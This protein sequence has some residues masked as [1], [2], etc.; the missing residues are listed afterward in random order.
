[1]RNLTLVGRFRPTDI[2][3]APTEQANRM[4]SS[5]SRQLMIFI[6]IHGL[7]GHVVTF[8]ETPVN[9]AADVGMQELTFEQH[10]RPILKVACFHCH[11]EEENHEGGL[12]LRLV[13]L[14]HTGGES[15]PAVL[16][17]N[18]ENS[19]IWERISSDEMPEGSTKL[20]P[21][22]K[23]TIRQWIEQGTK[24]A[25]PEPDNVED[26]RFT[27]EELN[28]WAFQ[29]VHR[30]NIPHVEGYA[31][32]SAVDAFVAVRLKDA[33]LPFSPDADRRTYIRRVTF[34]LIGLPPTSDEVACFVSDD[35]PNAH[36]RLV[37]RLLASPQ[38]GVRWGRHWLDVA[39][40]AESDGG[41]GVDR[42]REH[43]WRYRDY[44]VNSFNGD[45]P[46]HRFFQEQLAGDELIPAGT[47]A[48]SK[49]RRELL[50]ATG[51]LRMAPDATQ[52]SNTLADRNMAVADTLHVVSTATFGLTIGCAQCHDHKYDPVTIDDYYR[53]RAIF[54]PAF[55][56]Q[57][58][59]QPEARL[60]DVTPEHVM[61]ERK[62]IE[63][64]VKVLQEEL[65]QRRDQV[66]QQIQDRKLADVPSEFRDATRVAVL[67]KAAER[68]ARQKELLDL[69]PMVKPISTIR[70]LLVEYDK[71]SYR[72]FEK[73]QAEIDGVRSQMPPLRKIMATTERPG[74]IP[75]SS[76][77]FRGNPKSPKR[78][79]LP[80]EV[81]VL[82][83]HGRNV[84]IPD[85][86]PA[87]STT[88]RRLAFAKRL[89]DGTHPLAARVFVNR[90]WM[91]H[92]GRG[93]VNTPSDFGLSGEQPSHPALLDWLADD[94]V[95]HDWNLKRLHRMI[96][97]STTYRQQSK[98]TAAHDSVD[99]E[100][101]LLG[102]MNL[103]RLEAEAIRDAILAVSG[104]IDNS[105]G[106]PSAPVT[107][108]AEGKT[109]I[110]V[111][112]VKDGLKAGVDRANAE[113]F[114]RSIYIETQRSL[115]LNLLATFDQ[116]VMNPNC[117]V[118]RPSTVAT[119]SLWFLNDEFIIDASRR[120]AESILGAS[121][122]VDSKHLDQL[123]VR[124]FAALPSESEINECAVFLEGQANELQRI[125]SDANESVST[126]N[127]QAFR[128]LCQMLLASN[129]FLYVD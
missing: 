79:V 47:A 42:K 104:K 129:R 27:L 73:E 12:D 82:N 44:V 50:A 52:S 72:A 19:L 57:S 62:R 112:R 109:V 97:L 78:E 38:Y 113:A 122:I 53:L 115:P 77:F 123:F 11:G 41:Q 67:A 105:L 43:A 37:D 16:P 40:Y 119:Q 4:K 63:S 128:M 32:R 25:R 3:T 2:V 94:F 20:T 120:L 34:D 30:P 96:L 74:V 39:G 21:S 71:E 103:R 89:T 88:G 46:I 85:D 15:G 108:D 84:Q 18:L 80:S 56:L 64:E 29:P 92:I 1:M 59:L 86:D 76:V 81:T 126:T 45:I 36:S 125:S 61:A 35:R 5:I 116:P 111:R 23:Q 8:G 99:P 117:S 95:R 91:Y 54:D 101:E 83:R 107:E 26:A 110:G 51:F 70:G 66:C 75:K 55:P 93:L 48:R 127:V 121:E 9:T 7:L 118:R 124:L 24:T 68:T 69:Y 106:G 102:R 17:G 90:V 58:W 13:R 10:V 6:V 87:R 33:K 114:R 65:N 60:V 28:H 31:I 98:R 100:N 49:R 14:M 22:Q